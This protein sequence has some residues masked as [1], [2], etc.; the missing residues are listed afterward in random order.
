MTRRRTFR[1]ALMAEQVLVL[2]ILLLAAASIGRAQLLP[3]FGRPPSPP[4]DN[5][6]N[7]SNPVNAEC[8]APLAANASRCGKGGQL[9]RVPHAS[10]GRPA[11]AEHVL[12]GFCDSAPQAG[13]L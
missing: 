4:P 6:C 8:L 9:A 7:F 5:P 12:A 3:D 11:A 10:P 1:K 13:P 2:L